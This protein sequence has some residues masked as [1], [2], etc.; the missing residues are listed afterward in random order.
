MA[1]TIVPVGPGCPLR[2]VAS[3]AFYRMCA[4]TTSGEVRA[5]QGA[6]PAVA[7]GTNQRALAGESVRRRIGPA[8]PVRRRDGRAPAEEELEEGDGIG[9]V[10]A[11][12]VVDVRAAQ[13]VRLQPALKE[14]SEDVDRVADV[15]GAV[16]VGVA[17]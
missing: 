4:A 3:P 9:E 15:R 16:G 5:R 6:D 12:V 14:V 13:A 1:F 11:P 10:H 7:S 8:G 2:R 17:A